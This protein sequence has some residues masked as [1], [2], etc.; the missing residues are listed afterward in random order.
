MRIGLCFLALVL[1]APA[2][3]APDLAGDVQF[4]RAQS[5]ASDGPALLRFLEL[6]S[7]TAEERKT[8]AGDLRK[9]ASDSYDEREAATLRLSARGPSVLDE[10]RKLAKHDDA[11]VRRRV[12]QVI[13]EHELGPGPMLPAAVIRVLTARKPEGT[14]KALLRYVPFADDEAVEEELVA[15]LDTLT[16]GKPTDALLLDAVRDPAPLLRAVAGQVLARVGHP[17]V[18]PLLKD[19]EPR[20]RFRVALGRVA[21]KQRDGVPALI[22]L[23]TVER[24]QLCWQAEEVLF[25]L[26]GE[27]GPAGALSL[28]SAED[29][30]KTRTAWADWWRDQGASVDL[31]LVEGRQLGLTL[32]IEYNTGRVWE[33]GPDKALRF[34]LKG[35]QGP[36]E[37]QVLP[38]GRVLVAESN[39][40]KVTER[41][42]QGN[43]LWTLAIEVG[44]PTGCQRLANGNTFVSTYGKALEYRRD[45]TLA[46]SFSLPQGSNAIRKARNGNV[47][48]A[49][50]DA[51]VEMDTAGKEVRRIPIPK[52][53]MY[54]GLRDLPGERFLLANSNTGRVLEVDRAGK[55]LWEAR[56]SG[57]CGI[58]RTASGHTL[59]A[60]ANRVVELD[61]AGNTVWEVR[62]PG[63]V[64][65]VN[66]R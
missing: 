57:A 34:E 5:L 60:T 62:A 32:G 26:A 46:Y 14:L 7:P 33:S 43:V 22:D 12:E 20:V 3:D 21:A 50:D 56:V 36:M 47:I 17:A 11:E 27:K 30:A 61:R 25:R 10:V 45:G 18:V 66:R 29:R 49:T 48:F 35:L 65:R 51:I 37:A 19:V 16:R 58:D 2:A 59:V 54:V 64:R 41:D 13:Q 23:L 15:A 31:G 6:R 63:Y 39:G 1:A 8:I 52:Q 9:L 42:L 24:Q 44:E 4:L 28:A 38:G 53:S 55:I 40:K